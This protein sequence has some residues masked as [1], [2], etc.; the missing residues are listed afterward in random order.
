VSTDSGDGE[1]SHT[2]DS[3]TATE[4]TGADDASLRARLELLEAENDRLR[5]EYARATQSQ[6][7][8]TALALFALGAVALVGAVLFPA[9]REVLVALGGTGVFGAVL[10]HYLTPERVVTATV[11]DAV[12]RATADNFAAIVDA[13]GLTETRVYVPRTDGSTVRLFVPATA[14][15]DV[16]DAE[17]LTTPFVVTDEARG[18]SLVPT[19]RD[20]VGAF[21]RS[22][23]DALSDDPD[24]LG[25]QLTDALVEQFELL[26]RTDV[27]SEAGRLTVAFDTAVEGD[28]AAFDHPVVSFL[29]TATARAV[30][31]PVTV[32]VETG[33][34]R[35]EYLVTLRWA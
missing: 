7:R 8:Q 28:V 35:F 15:A 33:D 34:D 21:E 13:L 18:L 14:S 22:L 19:G 5:T 2:A 10:I 4:E 11:S 9:V 29:A 26:D 23:T 30:G 20:L 25:P 31:D 17:A 27:D 32:E 3:E 6:Y 1:P 24:R 16:P 12:S